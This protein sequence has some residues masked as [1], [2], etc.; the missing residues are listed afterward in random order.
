MKH[1]YKVFLI[2][3]LIALMCLSCPFHDLNNP[4]DPLSES[5]MGRPGNLSPEEG[6]RVYAL[7]VE[8][9]WEEPAGGADMYTVEIFTR[10]DYS[11]SVSK[12]GLTETS[13]I[14]TDHV[15]PDGPI[16][17]RIKGVN[18]EGRSGP[19][20]ESSFTLTKEV[21]LSDKGMA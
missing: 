15:F 7:A 9:S 2:S 4:M 6:T 5:Y 21:V 8:I 17:Y 18:A 16:Y 1:Q 10:E 14:I 11:N 12:D 3:L 13:V 20:A 19:W